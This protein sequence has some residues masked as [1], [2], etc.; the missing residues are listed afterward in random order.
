MACDEAWPGKQ[1]AGEG[2]GLDTSLP[3]SYDWQLTGISG[4]VTTARGEVR[5]WYVLREVDWEFLSTD[6]REAHI[7]NSQAASW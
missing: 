1:Q 6:Q 2:E 3:K 5:A 4:H 7:H